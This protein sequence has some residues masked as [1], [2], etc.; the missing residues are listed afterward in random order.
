M[1]GKLLFYGIAHQGIPV[2]VVGF[3]CAAI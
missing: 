1:D 3:F 2:A